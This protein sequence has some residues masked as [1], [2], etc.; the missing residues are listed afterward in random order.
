[1]DFHFTAP[2]TRWQSDKTTWHFIT[3]TP[4]V[5]DGVRFFHHS[6][7]ENQKRRGFGAIKVRAQIGD[8]S[9]TTSIFPDKASQS[10]LLPVKKQV[11]DGEDLAV[12]SD[13]SVRLNLQDL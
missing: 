5:A 8:T 13:V 10:F 4:E 1:M 2:L 7:A 3:L 6:M 11:R 12:G 9:W